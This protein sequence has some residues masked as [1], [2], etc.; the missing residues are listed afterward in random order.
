[1]FIDVRE[2]RLDLSPRA[3]TR[4]LEAACAPLASAEQCFHEHDCGPLEHPRR[5]I[6]SRATAWL[7]RVAP[8]HGNHR[9]GWRSGA[10]ENL[11]SCAPRDD[12][13]S[14][15]L[16]P[17][18]DR[19]GRLLSRPPL[20]RPVRSDV[21]SEG[22][23][24]RRVRLQ[25][26]RATGPCD[27]EVPRRNPTFTSPRHLPSQGRSRTNEGALSAGRAERRCRRRLFHCRGFRARDARAKP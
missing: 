22:G 3:L 23:R 8:I 24:H 12:C 13:S 15:R 19:F 20:A 5:R 4:E 1:V 14:R 21:G 16:R 26:A 9:T 2:H 18:L 11:S 7:D 10:E 27:A 6:A 25:G 17:D